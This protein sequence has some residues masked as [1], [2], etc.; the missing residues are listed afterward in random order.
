MSAKNQLLIQYDLHTVLF[1]NVLVDINDDEAEVRLAPEVNNVK[2]LAGH[3]VWGQLGLARMGNVAV[4]I[5]W[6]DL[7]NTQLKHPVSSDIKGPSMEAI[8]TEW[9]K[10]AQPIRD[11]LEKMT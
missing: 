7:Y 3:L 5:P 10:W 8:K 2:W 1:N 4:D 9:N 11:G 6:T